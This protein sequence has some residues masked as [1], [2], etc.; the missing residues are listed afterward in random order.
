MILPK[1]SDAIH[2]AWLYRLLISLIDDSIISQKIFFKGGTCL[3]MLNILD[4]FSVDLD[5]D[6]R[7]SV[8][9]QVLRP[10]LHK[11][12]KALNLEI[13]DESQNVLQFFLKYPAKTK[14]R[15]TIKLDIIDN[16][17]K[18][19]QYTAYYLEE[20]DRYVNC[21]TI[22]T[23]VA[24]KLVVATDRFNKNSSIAGRDVY[25]VHHFLVQ[26]LGYNQEV[27]K[28]RT[29]L[30][31][32]NYLQNLIKFINQKVTQ[33]IIDQDL[34]MLLTQDKFHSLRKTLKTEVLMLLKDEINR[35]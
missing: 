27:I 13:K 30:S 1:S 32:K 5:F 3:A 16:F 20:I 35:L 18:A 11:I 6:L 23:M 2:K 9:K 14:E 33:T 31:V 12:F 10:K 4:R 15:N 26:D 19:N 7:T 29:G 17:V 28:E 25:D 8:D 24:N 21:Q 34:N 22:E